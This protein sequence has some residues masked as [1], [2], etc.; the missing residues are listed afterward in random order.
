[1]NNFYTTM[2]HVDQTDMDSPMIYGITA[3]E[4]GTGK[5][6]FADYEIS[7]DPHTINKLS[8][9]CQKFQ[10]NEKEFKQVVACYKDFRG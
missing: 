10:P 6:M 1:M 2:S 7:F 5:V 4:I 3:K 9:I 8:N